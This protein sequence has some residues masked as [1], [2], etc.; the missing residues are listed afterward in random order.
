MKQVKKNIYIKTAILCTIIN[1]LFFSNQLNAKPTFK[2]SPKKLIIEQMQGR[3]STTKM[4]VKVSKNVDAVI[5]NIVPELKDWITVSP[6]FF[7]NL[8]KGETISLTVI[9]SLPLNQPLETLVCGMMYRLQYL[10]DTRMM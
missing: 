9:I 8:K 3:R 4:S 7:N 6:Y 10:T 2:W 5:I 1:I